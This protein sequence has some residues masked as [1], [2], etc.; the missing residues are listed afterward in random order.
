LALH[1]PIGLNKAEAAL[2]AE[3]LDAC[4]ATGQ[5]S[6]DLNELREWLRTSV[7]SGAAANLSMDDARTALITLDSV[8]SAEQP[9]TS[10]AE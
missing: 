1:Q 4:D 6:D 3:G 10:N 2:L 5:Q 9:T 8:P 7:M